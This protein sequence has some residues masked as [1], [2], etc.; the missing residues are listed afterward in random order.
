[1][2]AV[3]GCVPVGKQAHSLVNDRS[4]GNR[5]ARSQLRAAGQPE[6]HS[7]L[8]FA[9][10]ATL[11]H[12]SISDLSTF[13]NSSGELPTGVASLVFIANDYCSEAKR[14]EV[15]AFFKEKNAKALGGPRLYDNALESFTL[16]IAYR[17]RHQ[18]SLAKVLG[19][20]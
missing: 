18:D 11:I 9:A 19:R 7:S 8:M 10:L 17:A 1:M 14:D 12:F 4:K 5:S 16:C 20:Y 3:F 2:N 15:A 13:P 6:A